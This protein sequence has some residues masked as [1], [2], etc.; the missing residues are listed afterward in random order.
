MYAREAT[1]ALTQLEKPSQKLAWPHDLDSWLGR[2]MVEGRLQ[3]PYLNR[4]NSC[5]QKQ[6][7]RHSIRELLLLIF[8]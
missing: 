1:A 4:T 8:S 5:R 3:L 7:R 2:G 6:S